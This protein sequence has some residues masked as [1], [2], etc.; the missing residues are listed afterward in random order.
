M[1]RNCAWYGGLLLGLIAAIPTAAIGRESGVQLTP[2]QKRVLV[3]KDVAEQRY[4]IT[5]NVDDDSVTGNVFFTDGGAPKFVACLRVR[6]NVFSCRVADACTAS[7]RQS[8]IQLVPNSSAVLVGKDVEDQRYAITANSDGSLTGNIFLSAT[9]TAKFIF[10]QPLGGD[11]YSCSIADACTVEPCF[12]QFGP[13]VI[14]TLPSTFFSVPAVC[15]PYGDVIE[16]ELPPGFLSANVTSKDP[17]DVIIPHCHNYCNGPTKIPPMFVRAAEAVACDNPDG[18][19]AVV[20]GGILYTQCDLGSVEFDGL[21]GTPG[22][23][24]LMFDAFQIRDLDTG[25]RLTEDGQLLVTA[26]GE[27]QRL[28]GTLQISTDDLGSYVLALEGVVI[29]ATGK[30]IAG[31]LR[32]DVSETTLENVVEIVVTTNGG[33]L[34]PTILRALGGATS[35]FTFDTDTG[36]LTPVDTEPTP[37]VIM[38][39]PTPTPVPTP[40][41]DVTTTKADTRTPTPT[42]TRTATPTPTPT[43]TATRTP[44]PTRT[45][46]PIPSATATP[47]PCVSAQNC[48]TGNAGFCVDHCSGTTSIGKVCAKS[49][50]GPN[51]STDA[52]CAGTDKPY[53]ISNGF[54][55]G[56]QTTCRALQTGPTCGNGLCQAGENESNCPDDCTPRPG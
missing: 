8:G 1:T 50:V 6:E 20:A 42:S 26:A 17:N 37:I 14:V 27:N 11:D 55:G 25:S 35:S 15:P 16:V 33:R 31:Q 49:N 32:F 13:P 36:I 51:C 19:L 29:D 38:T 18:D 28:D 40:A 48:G 45:A 10:C 21:L 12:D 23:G 53:C 43:S 54:C 34:L 30:A 41:A 52:S 4:A 44:T 47:E 5:S 24:T 9:G 3:S 46:T 2:D 7:G 39:P 56:S 22:N